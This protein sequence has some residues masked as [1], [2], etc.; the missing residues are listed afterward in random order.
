LIQTHIQELSN[1][2]CT[3]FGA[4][5]CLLLFVEIKQQWEWFSALTASMKNVESMPFAP[6]K[7][8]QRALHLHASA[9]KRLTARI[10]QQRFQILK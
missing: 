1:P 8:A 6:I 10:R 2:S 5:G 9:L 3:Y 7:I 4:H